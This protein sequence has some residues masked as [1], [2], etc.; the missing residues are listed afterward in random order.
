MFS[1]RKRQRIRGRALQRAIVGGRLYRDSKMAHPD[2]LTEWDVRGLYCIRANRSSSRQ[3]A[4]RPE[5]SGAGGMALDGS[6]LGG[7][8]VSCLSRAKPVVFVRQCQ[9]RAPST[10]PLPP[11]RSH[12]ALSPYSTP[13]T[14]PLPLLCPKNT[15]YTH[16]QTTDTTPP[17][18]FSLSITTSITPL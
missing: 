9:V 15:V 10:R 18:S 2:G 5:P 3:Q 12:T 8:L 14:I 6:V 13:C 4:V 16:P 17:P 1:L 11:L 7:W